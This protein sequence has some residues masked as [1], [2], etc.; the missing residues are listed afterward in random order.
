[1]ALP[2]STSRARALSATRPSSARWAASCAGGG[3][4]CVQGGGR[5]SFENTRAPSTSSPSTTGSRR[6]VVNCAGLYADRLA[7][8]AERGTYTAPFRGEYYELIPR[9]HLPLSDVDLPRA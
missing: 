4:G 6:R 1:M 5:S 9:A 7:G 8:A 2:R 3:S